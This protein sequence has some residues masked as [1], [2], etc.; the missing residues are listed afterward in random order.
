[1]FGCLR[2]PDTKAVDHGADRE[3]AVRQKFHNVETAGIG[4]GLEGLD[5]VK[6]L[7]HRNIPVKE[8]FYQGIFVPDGPGGVRRTVYYTVS[9]PNDSQ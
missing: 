4:Q 5:R 2:L 1:M 9:E 6:L 8:Y 7:S 3:W